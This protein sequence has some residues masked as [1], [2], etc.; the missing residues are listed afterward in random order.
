MGRGAPTPRNLQKIC[1]HMFLMA[2]CTWGA[3]VAA[4]GLQDRETSKKAEN[5]PKSLIFVDFQGF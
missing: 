2:G 1:F 3:V 4:A 5:V